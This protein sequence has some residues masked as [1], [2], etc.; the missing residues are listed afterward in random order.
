[1]LLAAAGEE[2]GWRGFALPRLLERR[3]PLGATLVLAAVVA[4]WHLPMFWYREGFLGMGIAEATGF[5]L[6]LTAGAIVLT[7]IFLAAHGSALVTILWHGMLSA[8]MA[9]EISE[10]TVNAAISTAIMVA[11]AVI[12]VGWWG[13]G[14]VQRGAG[15]R[16]AARSGGAA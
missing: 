14:Q 4:V 15:R 6:G 12:L 1:M 11:G 13:G 10:G 5:M 16:V 3:G 8:A 2:I 9:S 7:R